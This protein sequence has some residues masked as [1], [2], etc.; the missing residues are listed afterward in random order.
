[1]N[2]LDFKFLASISGTAVGT[3]FNP[4]LNSALSGNYNINL[5]SSE[6]GASFAD[7]ALVV[8]NYT[9]PA[10]TGIEI[11]L[12]DCAFP[13]L[14][15]EPIDSA[16]SFSKIKFYA[17]THELAST[18]SAL[19]VGGTVTVG[20]WGGLL[21]DPDGS[22]TLKPGQFNIMGSMTEE[23]ME[24]VGEATP[25]PTSPPRTTILIINADMNNDAIFSLR[26]YGEKFLSNEEQS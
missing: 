26:I 14:L 3:E 10:G 9:L 19:V 8:A 1:M 24:V 16:D 22:L 6:E 2:K 13:N 5:N 21:T 11:G 12:V 7:Q 25:N 23:G 4:V 15:N 17:I 18:A 20:A